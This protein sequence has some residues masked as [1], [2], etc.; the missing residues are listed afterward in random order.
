MQ[1][2]E[3]IRAISD[4]FASDGNAPSSFGLSN[5]VWS[6]GQFLGALL[7]HSCMLHMRAPPLLTLPLQ[8]LVPLG[9]DGGTMGFAGS[10]C[11]M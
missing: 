3:N 7:M 6:F 4:E 2:P 11:G 8:Q 10:P 5:M 1:S 9:P